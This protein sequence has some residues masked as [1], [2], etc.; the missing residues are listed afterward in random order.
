MRALL[1]VISPPVT[2]TAVPV[3][4][5]VFLMSLVSVALVSLPLKASNATSLA[6]KVFL[7]LMASA[8][9]PLALEV[10][11]VPPPYSTPV[12]TVV[13][14]F[15]TL[16]SL[17]ACTAICAA[18]KELLVVP[19]PKVMV[20]LEASSPSK[21]KRPPAAPSTVTL[22]PEL[23]IVVLLSALMVK[24]AAALLEFSSSLPV[25]ASAT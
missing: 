3:A 5:V 11:M 23:L 12:F 2:L 10:I 7:S 14:A 8:A 9:P 4:S 20:A 16:G 19:L 21:I 22:C 25:V 15:F 17:W 1:T 13:T 18:L 6:S 24:E